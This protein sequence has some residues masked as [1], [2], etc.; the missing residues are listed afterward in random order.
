MMAVEARWI[1]D[2]LAALTSAG[3]DIGPV[4]SIGSGSAPYRKRRQPWIDE[5]IYDPL[6]A[7]GVTVIHH[8]MEQL[9]GVDVVGDLTDPAFL[10]T[11]VGMGVRSVLCCN[12]LEHLS[13][14]RPL[15][16]AL[17]ELLPVGGHAVVTVPHR[18]PYHADPI[19][20]MY[21][22]DLA[23]LSAELTAD[24][25]FELVAGEV[26]GCESLFGYWWSAPAKLDKVKG[27]ARRLPS[28]VSRGGAASRPVTSTP[29][30]TATGSVATH[31]APHPLRPR[32]PIGEVV[33][34]LAS[35]TEVTGVVLRRT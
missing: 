7:R 1:A 12:V 21:R 26:I 33:G 23:E 17:G 19:D 13:D 20:T 15:E 8:E 28:I 3:H 9:P 10:A 34:M 6:A 31:V 30:A 24:G 35:R 27:L 18:F 5:A 22:P 32:E 29:S 4:L 25:A 2:Q 11:L 16:L 14:R